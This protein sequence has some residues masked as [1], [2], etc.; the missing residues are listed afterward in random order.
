MSL[1][2]QLLSAM[3]DHNAEAIAALVALDYDSQ[4][5]A[6][7]SRSFRGRDQVLT[8]WLSVFAGVPDF[9]AELVTLSVDGDVEVGEWAWR[10]THVDGSPF[11]MRGATVFGVGD[12]LIQWARLYMEPVELAGDDADIDQMVRDTYRPPQLS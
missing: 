3:N 2:R 12:W 6:H 5:P 7:P 1:T 9:Y 10:G 8:N 4:Q 11:A